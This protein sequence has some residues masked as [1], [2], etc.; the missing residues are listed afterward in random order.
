M[1]DIK[2]SYP[3]I[4]EKNWW[5]LR[6]KFKQ[7]PPV[8]GVSVDYLSNLLNI[9]KK[10]A[11][12]I[13]PTLKKIGI[14][15]ES[16]SIQDRAFK[17]RDDEQYE[18]VCNEILKEIYPQELIDLYPKPTNDD[19]EPISRWFAN[20]GKVG[21]ATSKIMASFYILLSE[22]NPTAESEVKIKPKTEKPKE[23]TKIEQKVRKSEETDIKRKGD[24]EQELNIPSININVEIHISSDASDTQIDKIF[25][26]MAT[27]LNIRRKIN[28]E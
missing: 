23:K 1:A 3:T 26:S 12:N 27:H 28:N 15:D 19:K 17:W 21:E 14:I 5:E 25:E 10:A 8:S 22:A 2:E 11:A 7:S 20:K 18:K 13:R 24:M 6:K 4:P 16:G 9:S